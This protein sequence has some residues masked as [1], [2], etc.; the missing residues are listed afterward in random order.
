MTPSPITIRI[1]FR[2]YWLL[3]C[4]G[5]AIAFTILLFIRHGTK[6][7]WPL[8]GVLLVFIAFASAI[9]TWWMQWLYMV[10]LTNTDIKGLN[11]L[12]FPTTFLWDEVS[13]IKPLNFLGLKW[14]RILSTKHYWALW[15]PL[16][17]SNHTSTLESIADLDE[18]PRQLLTY[19]EPHVLHVPP[20]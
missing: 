14:L 16:Q 3:I 17:I 11:S 13:E 6:I 5:A 15:V 9:G 20:V 4:A 12:C 2:I 8:Y 7:D 19:L 1:A 18:K 10:R